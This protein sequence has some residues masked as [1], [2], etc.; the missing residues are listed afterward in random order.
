MGENNLCSIRTMPLSD[1]QEGSSRGGG[2]RYLGAE[3]YSIFLAG[4]EEL[5]QQEMLQMI[6]D[7]NVHREIASSSSELLTSG[8]EVVNE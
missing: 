2:E 5:S 1:R 7:R 6:Q 4:G 8:G 3:D